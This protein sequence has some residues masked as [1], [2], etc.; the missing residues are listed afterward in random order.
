MIY[1]RVRRTKARL[2]WIINSIENKFF[3]DFTKDVKKKLVGSFQPIVCH[4]FKDMDDIRFF[5]NIRVTR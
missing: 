4:F 2:V 5:P 3:E 1:A